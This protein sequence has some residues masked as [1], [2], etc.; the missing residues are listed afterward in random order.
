MIF[1]E[2][3]AEQTKDW[4]TVEATDKDGMRTYEFKIAKEFL[5]HSFRSAGTAV[6][7]DISYIAIT[8][9]VYQ[10][11]SGTSGSDYV[12]T[13]LF[14]RGWNPSSEVHTTFTAN[15]MNLARPNAGAENNVAHF[16]F[17]GSNKIWTYNE[18]S[19]RINSPWGLRFRTEISKA[20][21]EE[22]EKAYGRY[23]DI[24]VG[25]IIAPTDTLEDIE[26]LTVDHLYLLGIE[27]LDVEA[28]LEAPYAET[29]TTLIYTGSITDIIAKN[30]DRDFSARG[31]IAYTDSENTLHY[32]YSASIATRNATEVAEAALAALSDTQEGAYQYPVTVGDTVKYSRYDEAQRDTLEKLNPEY[33][34][35]N[36]VEVS[37][38]LVPKK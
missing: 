3:T 10:Y 6:T 9:E 37:D 8:Y 36:D 25:T 16:V 2:P 35:P 38:P 11:E 19:T 22:L 13:R 5:A 1:R 28:T 18:A 32:V 24:E 26:Q 12:Y 23:G 27:Y 15:G 33:Y 4:L 29:D 7:D 34:S 20:Y 31:Y 17:F 30:L 21:I 14:Q